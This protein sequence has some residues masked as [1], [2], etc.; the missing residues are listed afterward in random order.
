VG[1]AHQPTF[2]ISRLITGNS[3]TSRPATRAAPRQFAHILTGL[4]VAVHPNSQ[5]HGIGS[6]LFKA[7]F[8]HAGTLR[9]LVT[10]VELVVR[11]GSD[12]AV[13]L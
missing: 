1:L 8:E 10:S 3:S 11:L 12:G 9:P 2:G 13:L 7:L 6:S 5:G 4:A